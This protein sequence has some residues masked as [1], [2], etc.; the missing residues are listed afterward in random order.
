MD[1]KWLGRNAGVIDAYDKDRPGENTIY[2]SPYEDFQTSSKLLRIMVTSRVTA[3]L[4]RQKSLG[5]TQFRI[6]R[7]E[8]HQVFQLCCISHWHGWKNPDRSILY[9][10]SGFANSSSD[11]INFLSRSRITSSRVLCLYP[12][13]NCKN[14]CK[15]INALYYSACFVFNN[16]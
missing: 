7:Q 6:F 1:K 2:G 9:L 3:K 4:D 14:T 15:Y 5:S 8:E 16:I 11:C 10:Y 13:L 12:S